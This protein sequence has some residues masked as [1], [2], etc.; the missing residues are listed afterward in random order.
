MLSTPPAHA[1]PFRLF[2]AALLLGAYLLLYVNTPA[3]ADGKA[4]LAVASSFALHGRADMNAVAASDEILPPLARLGSAGV[5]GALYAK[6]GPTPSLAIAPLVW[7][8]DRLPRLGIRAT[9]MLFNA[10]VTLAAALLLFTFARWL[11]FRPES[12]LLLG[13]IYG[14]CTLAAVYVKTLFGEPL[15]ALLL[16]AAVMAAWRHRAGAQRGAL[17]LC[18]GALIAVAGIN[19]VYAVYAPIVALYAFWGRIRAADALR[20]VMPL[21]V[22]AGLLALYNWARFGGLLETGYHFA[23]GEGF[24][25]P[26]GAGLFGL[27]LSP[28]RGLLPYNPVLL[29]A[30]PGAV[31]LLRREARLTWALLALIAVQALALA[32]WWSWHGGILW[33]PR[34]MLPVLPLAVLLLAPVIDESWRRRWLKVAVAALAVVSFGIQLLGGLYSYFPYIGYLYAHYAAPGYTSLASG[35]ADEVVYRADLSP[36]LGHLAMALNGWPL[37]P[38]WA[39]NG[40]ALHALAALLV[41]LAGIAGLGAPRR[42]GRILVAAVAVA[43]MGVVAARQT[44]A[45]AMRA[46]E[47]AALEAALDPPGTVLIASDRFGD[48]LLDV[49]RGWLVISMNA[50]NDPQDADVRARWNFARVQGP[51]LWLVNWFPPSSPDNWQERE[52]WQEAAFVR[53]TPVNGHRAL[54]FRLGGAPAVQ[55]PG[56]WRFG[57]AIQ[58]ES[59]GVQ[60]TSGGLLVGL[61]WSAAQTPDCACAWF[62]HLLDADGQIVAQQ[63][64]APQG[65]Y[66]PTSGWTRD[67]PVE[68]RLFFPLE[69]RQDV[70]GWRLRVG[71]V[72]P[73]GSAPLAVSGPDGAEMD[74]PFVL[75][76]L[77]LF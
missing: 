25:Q 65:G 22:G 15:A 26:L 5:D 19:T 39:A 50:P 75:L 14:L 44:D 32:S 23:E 4:L 49:G 10:L 73:G 13:L 70:T 36:I 76:P 40:D 58:L 45:P 54:L 52:L 17:V 42:A 33:G 27:L 6:K 55:E 37:E 60:R 8:A 1:Q 71:W 47:V 21:V 53:E 69:R 48:A 30:I 29:L 57:E 41:M 46:A 9:A 11:G 77:A 56:G 2:L 63:D 51:Y 38:A 12:A 61:R 31:M 35:L 7:L 67:A 28:Y 74:D 64:R 43:G 68:D 34:F 59:Y 72:E 62:V 20:F 24:I 3:E 18:G 66:A 16:L